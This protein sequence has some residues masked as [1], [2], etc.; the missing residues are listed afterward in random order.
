MSRRVKEIRQLV[1][2][3]INIT[4]LNPMPYT[5][6]IVIRDFVSK[7]RNS[8]VLRKFHDRGESICFNNAINF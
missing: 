2:E 4:H 8:K 7:N 3:K 5:L 1:T 6:S